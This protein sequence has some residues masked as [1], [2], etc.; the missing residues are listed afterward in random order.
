MTAK[1]ITQ[2]AKKCAPF[3]RAAGQMPTCPTDMLALV[4]KH[5]SETEIDAILDLPT[6]HLDANGR[7]RL[8]S[9]SAYPAFCEGVASF[10]WET[11]DGTS[12]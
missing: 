8:F 12:R 3:V 10:A 7:Q 2:L 11:V 1:E 9:I 5:L 4:G 6:G